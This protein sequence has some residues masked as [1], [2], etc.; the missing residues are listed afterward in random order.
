M[1][2]LKVIHGMERLRQPLGPQQL[3]QDLIPALPGDPGDGGRGRQ[4]Q[5]QIALPVFPQRR[6]QVGFQRLGVFLAPLDEGVLIF[7]GE[8]EPNEQG[9][10]RVQALLPLGDLV[11]VEARIV[12]DPG[13]P[14]H[15]VV[16]RVGLHDHLPGVLVRRSA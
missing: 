1:G 15:R 7:A 16:R 14:E 9:E 2:G 4:E 5:Q 12:L 10:G 8:Q 11:L 3:H 6:S 13:E